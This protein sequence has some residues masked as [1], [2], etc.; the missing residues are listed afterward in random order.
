MVDC[1]RGSPQNLFL[2]CK[3][4]TA[5]STYNYVMS[6]DLPSERASLFRG[7]LRADKLGMPANKTDRRTH[8]K[9]MRTDKISI[10]TDKVSM[11]ANS[12]N[13]PIIRV[14]TPTDNLGTRRN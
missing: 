8:S 10:P 11:P 5:K 7:R 1:V 12:I 13:R 3:K 4:I 14:G 9:N 2:V 6:P